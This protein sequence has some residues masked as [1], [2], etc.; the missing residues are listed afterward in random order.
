MG[1]RSTSSTYVLSV[2]S[3]DRDMTMFP[4]SGEYT[5]KLPRVYA[6]VEKVEL[7]DVQLPMSFYVFDQSN[8]SITTSLYSSGGT[9]L[10][11]TEIVT[12]PYGNY[13]NTTLVAALQTA[14]NAAFVA[15]GGVR[16]TV[17]LDTTTLL[18]TFTNDL[19]LYM[20]FDTTDAGTGATDWGLGY[21]LGFD[22]DA[23]TSRATTI[24]TP[25]TANLNPV[26]Y[27]YLDIDPLNHLDISGRGGT[28][29]VQRH[30]FAKIPLPDV[31]FNIVYLDSK[32]MSMPPAMLAPPVAKLERLRIKWKKYD[33]DVLNFNDT[34]HSFQL[35]VTC[36]D[37]AGTCRAG[38]VRN[39]AF[40]SS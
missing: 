25:N 26:T 2:D 20:E 29:G 9:V 1:E 17:T 39:T 18:I 12:I 37:R 28:P 38:S 31:S 33:G 10:E 32:T 7:L 11:A 14:L 24:T 30:A 4:S 16:F 6:N 8:S 34:E 22:R 5:V 36:C 40:Q 35:R 13:T 3:R 15:Q 23:I 21:H 19:G 27:V